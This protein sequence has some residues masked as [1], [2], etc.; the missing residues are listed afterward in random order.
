[1]DRR[2]ASSSTDGPRST[3]G[4]IQRRRAVRLLVAL[5][6]VGIVV[7]GGMAGSASAVIPLIYVDADAT[8][9][10]NGTSWTNAYTDLQ[11]ALNAATAPAQIW[12]AAGTY[13]PTAGTDRSISFVLKEGVTVYGG[14]AGTE[15][16]L[17]QR[18]WV[19][20]VTN[21]SGNI[22][23]P[24]L[25]TDNSETVVM[26]GPAMTTATIF[27][28]FTVRDGY[29]NQRAAG[30]LCW[31]SPTLSHLTIS[32]NQLVGNY[33]MGAG[34]YNA[35]SPALSNVTFDSNTVSPNF[36]VTWG[37][38]NSGGGL[39]SDSGSPV[40]TNVSFISNSAW[41]ERGQGA[42]M[43]VRSGSASL[44]TVSFSG[45]AA[46]Q[47]DTYPGESAQGAG[48]CNEAGSLTLSYVTFT[49]NTLEGL[50]GFGGG[51]FNGSGSATLDH[52]DFVSNSANPGAGGALHNDTGALDLSDVTFT[53]NSVSGPAGNGGAIF[54]FEGR[55][56]LTDCVFTSNTSTGSDSSGGAIENEWEM[57]LDTVTL[58]SNSVTGVNVTGGGM[59]SEGYSTLV[60]V[61]FTDNA[62]IGEDSLGN[63]ASCRGG[64]FYGQEG[65]VSMTDVTFDGNSASGSYAY[66]AGMYDTYPDL[67]LRLTGVVFDSN[68]VTGSANAGGGGLFSQGDCFLSDVDFT[69]NSAIGSGS[70][71]GFGGG[72]YDDSYS[73]TLIRLSQVDFLGNMVSGAGSCGGGLWTDNGL[74]GDYLTFTSNQAVGGTED[75]GG[76]GAAACLMGGETSLSHVAF[77]TNHATGEGLGGAVQSNAPLSLTDATFAGNTAT[78]ARAEGGAIWSAAGPLVVT[79]GT[80]SNNSAAANGG[81]VQVY[82][83]N[84]S[85]SGVSFIGNQAGAAGGAIDSDTWTSGLQA[86]DCRFQGNTAANN[87]GAVCFVGSGNSTNVVNGLFAANTAGGDGGALYLT[88]NDATFTNTT[89][90]K[91]AAGSTTGKGGALYLGS[92]GSMAIRNSILWGDTASDSAEIF[93]GVSSATDVGVA[94]SDVGD[95]TGTGYGFSDGG[96]NISLSPLFVDTTTNDFHLATSPTASPCIDVGD[97]TATALSGVHQ[98]LGGDTRIMGT[99][100]DMGA[101]EAAAAGAPAFTSSDGTTFKAGSAGSFS[102]ATTYG[103]DIPTITM[104]SADP[105]VTL[106]AWLNFTDDE[107]GTATLSGTPTW[108]VG[109]PTYYELTLTADNGVGA[110]A[111]QTFGLHLIAP[112]VVTLHPESQTKLNGLT[113]TFTATATGY[114]AP[115]V[116]WEYRSAGGTQ[117]MFQGTEVEQI[118][119]CV[120]YTNGMSFRATFTNEAG[121]AVS[122]AATLTVQS[123]PTITSDEACVFVKGF[124]DSFTVVATGSPVPALTVNPS[125]LPTGVTFHDNGDGTG[126]LAGA[127]TVRSELYSFDIAAS[128]GVGSVWTQ[129]FDLYVEG[130]PWITT[131][132]VS[133]TANA[134]SG[135]VTFTV[136]GGGEPQAQL[137]WQYRDPDDVG[138][139]DVEN[140][141]SWYTM[142]SPIIELNGHQYRLKV[143]NNYGTIYSDPATL[144]VTSPPAITSDDN[145]TFILGSPGSFAVTATGNPTPSLGCTG[146]LPAGVTFTD[147][148]DGTATLAG[149]P[150]GSTATYPLTITATN[151]G[152]SD[153]QDFELIVGA[154]PNVTDQPDD[155]TVYETEN[156][157]FTVAVSGYPAPTLQW[158]EDHGSG[159]QSMYG[160][161]R[162]TLSLAGVH[163]GSKFKVAVTNS[164]G[165]VWSN[166]ATLTVLP[167]TFPVVKL[168]PANAVVANGSTATFTAK[169]NSFPVAEAYWE[170]S[171]NSGKSWSFVSNG[172]TAVTGASDGDGREVSTSFTTASTGNNMNGNLYRA[173]FTTYAG[174]VYSQAA[175]LYVYGRV[176]RPVVTAVAPTTGP[177]G[178]SVTITGSNF[179]GVSTVSFGTTSAVFQVISPTQI[180]AT[181]PA[182]TIGLVGVSV[183]NSAG[184]SVDTTADDFTYVGDTTPNT[185]TFAA[186]TGVIPGTV[187]T[188]NTVTISGIDT[189][190]AISVSGTA[191]SEYRIDGG[192]W[193]SAPGFITDGQTVA[194]HHSASAGYST[195][196]STTLTIGGVDGTFSSTTMAW[197]VPTVTKLTPTYGP[198]TGATSVTI[199]GTYLTGATAVKFGSTPATN[200][201]VVSATSIT[202]TSPAHLSG[203]VSV[204]VT[205]PGG[206]STTAGTANDFTYRYTR[207]EENSTLLSYHTG[208]TIS[209]SNPGYSA[210]YIRTRTSSGPL[211][212][213]FT[214]VGFRVLAAKGPAYGKL[215]VTIDGTTTYADLYNA[216]PL[217][218]QVAVSRSALTYG[219]HTVVLDYSTYKNALSGGT[220]VNFDAL[221]IDGTL[222]AAYTRYEEDHTR[223]KYAAPW[224]VLSGGS[225]SGGYI[226]TRSS[227]GGVLTFLFR[228]TGFGIVCAKGPAYGKLKITIDGTP[229]TGYPDLYNATPLSKQTVYVKTG[230]TYANHTV[231]IDYSGY[232]NADSSGRTVNLDALDIYGTLL[233]AP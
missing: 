49:S 40:L 64:G 198:T 224:T 6:L 139:S 3:R 41:G 118:I 98:D 32:Y 124:Y 23:D 65:G 117:W 95:N 136:E 190:T 91:N 90:S 94:Y 62:V 89:F 80:F 125:D 179:L 104:E 162:A 2:T 1:M 153:S 211:T 43:Y 228:G 84:S 50:Y 69:G 130:L 47:S 168:Q 205:T 110:A 73:G 166:V 4:S 207:Y 142:V 120:S 67:D 218:Q 204:T 181:A 143:W 92:S 213:T 219:T 70:G 34:M 144:T 201:S 202:C 82:S 21:L 199:T 46:G 215:K 121:A 27:D 81:A 72:F 126:T 154:V 15:T 176:T 146:T 189:A 18:N 75:M 169:A 109:Q 36:F 85:F 149:T 123:S 55:M 106:P 206:T 26:A 59:C 217:Y 161:T 39:Y 180:N 171:T 148:H 5:L 107:D 113:A 195:T 164:A 145:T 88:G 129:N 100:V 178:T 115:T 87:G 128:N 101:Y 54:N 20:N 44:T 7:L 170:V 174:S 150:S 79:G 103:Q 132:P 14:F 177:A 116:T 13:H 133:Q 131:Q 35:G 99:A 22:G 122:D 86:R 97:S 155:A 194:V 210:S 112:P 186:A 77:N 226:R 61:T 56:G 147:N 167:A 30:I 38:H 172:S 29:D 187:Q 114:P 119:S 157:S 165:S 188:S 31:G 183:T 102:I 108:S 134:G 105:L 216:T 74:E 96:S 160:E 53:G 45:N 225:Y 182:H 111:T 93:N 196:V 9:S 227:S 58:T 200:V 175:T 42:G 232:K 221:E 192:S 220:A 152:G 209:P 185:F 138:W 12:V 127:P 222:K 140:N 60:H 212:F 19:T 63:P 159:W 10:N 71:A 197:P 203:L 163:S 230:L 141:T 223:I 193:T 78:G 28:G 11:A 51:M 16:T 233:Q 191:G 66:G 25:A 48:L 52:V 208:W 231:T 83:G 156:V 8:G 229:L 173:C 184:T 17:G 151:A 37:T 135:P 137:Q 214:G 158:W 24:A 33:V 76:G 68:T 57:T